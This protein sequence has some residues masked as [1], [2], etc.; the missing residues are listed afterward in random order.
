M[1]LYSQKFYKLKKESEKL[2]SDGDAP[3]TGNGDTPVKTEKATTP[4]SGGR[5]RKTE[6]DGTTAAATPSKRAKAGSKKQAA[7]PSPTTVKTE[8]KEEEE[9][10]DDG[11]GVT[12]A[13]AAADDA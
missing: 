12:D 10:D 9:G 5:K 3:A 6:A 1:S 11:D 7:R 4:K 13:P 2:L 8:V